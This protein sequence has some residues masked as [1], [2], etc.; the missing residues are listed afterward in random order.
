MIVIT[1]TGVDCRRRHGHG[2]DIASVAGSVVNMNG[3]TCKD[4][5]AKP[6]PTTGRVNG[7][8]SPEAA[9]RTVAGTLARGK[10][11]KTGTRTSSVRRRS[12]S[13]STAPEPDGV[14][15]GVLMVLAAPET[16]AEAVTVEWTV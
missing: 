14:K 16:L 7:A 3:V 12:V 8:M 9:S 5:D 15:R 11:L 2:A 10:V 1:D 4:D 6:A 13:S